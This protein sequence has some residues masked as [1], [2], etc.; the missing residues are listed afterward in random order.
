MHFLKRSSRPLSGWSLTGYA[1][2]SG[3]GVAVAVY[4]LYF[5]AWPRPA[6]PSTPAALPAQLLNPQ[7][8]RV[9]ATAGALALLVGLVQLGPWG[10]TLPPGWHRGAGYLYSA[11]VLISGLSGLW[12]APSS[13]G[14]L[15]AHF[16]FGSLAALWLTMTTWGVCAAIQGDVAAHRRAMVRSWALTCA[17]ITLRLQL[18]LC[19]LIGWEFASFYPWVAWTCW[20]PNLAFAQY[21][22]RRK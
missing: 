12:L 14:G 2:L 1:L 16:G 3:L 19:G 13:E 22:L 20:V 17:G 15:I 21:L 7:T 18:P 10:R 6:D 9:H 5:Y 11:A 4:A 8:L